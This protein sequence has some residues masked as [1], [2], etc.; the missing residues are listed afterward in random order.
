MEK[1]RKNRWAPAFFCT[2]RQWITILALSHRSI[3]QP[4][5]RPILCFPRSIQSFAD[6]QC[7]ERIVYLI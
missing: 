7:N 5:P 6:A 2:E 1:Q 4:L 3:K